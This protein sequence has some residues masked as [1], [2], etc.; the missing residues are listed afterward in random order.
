MPFLKYT[1]MLTTIEEIIEKKPHLKDALRLYEK[2]I[3]FKR[4]V[5]GMYKNPITFEDIAYPAEVI[6]AI[7]KDFSSIFGMPE[8]NLTALKEAMKFGQIDFTRLPLNE[9]PAFSLPYHEDELTM[10]LFLIS[11]P[12]FLWIR[13]SYNIDNI[14]WQEGRCP[15][16]NSSPSIASIDKDGRKHLYCSFCETSGYFKRIGCPICLNEDTS[17]AN[18]ITAEGEDG[19]RIDTCD[20]CGSYFKTVEIGLLNDLNPDIADLI[21]LPLDIIAQNK[22]YRRLSP[23]PLGMMRMV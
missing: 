11:K 21:S 4:S 23:N 2:V 12:Y 13:D 15:V 22:G 3:E 14:F 9:I 20:A 19:F 18:I 8:E 16:C 7:F 10:M 1:G 6:S 17:K 5:S